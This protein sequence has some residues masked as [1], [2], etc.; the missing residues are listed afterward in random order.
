MH[1]IICGTGQVGVS[2]AG[3][4]ALENDV[5]IVDSNAERVQRTTETHDV[6]GMIGVP[7]HPDILKQAGAKDADMIIAVTE[8][9]E[10]NMIACQVAHSIFGTPL[11]I[12][13]IR[14]RSYL[15]PLVG[16]LYSPENLPIDHIISPESEVSEA[17]G[18]RLLVPGAFDVASM[19]EKKVRIV[20]VRCEHNCPILDSSLRQLTKLFE[21]LQITV[22][23]ILRGNELIVPRDG[24]VKMEEGDRVYFVCDEEQMARAMASFGHEEPASSNVLIAGAGTVGKMVAEEVLSL[25]ED[26]R[27]T[28]IEYNAETANEAA[29]TLSNAITVINGNAL[30]AEILQESEVADADTFIALTDDD[31]V[32]VLSSLL[33][34]RY[35]ATHTVAL[36]NMVS[37]VPLISNLGVDSVINPPA[38]TVSSI[39]KHVRRGKVGDIHTIAED[40]GEFMEVE[41][42]PSSPLVGVPLRSAKLPKSI[43]VGAVVHDGVVTAPRGDTVIEPGDRVVLFAAREAIAE[44]E[45]LLSVSPDFF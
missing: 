13:R 7:S 10:I 17:V 37:F 29:Q 16:D 15:D 14:A 21:G 35:G 28:M 26:S 2:I 39:L 45:K 19:V 34:K 30:E 32:N 38:M 8:S 23:A 33:A 31:E 24:S 1:I 11:K 44:L 18:S 42:M 22:V 40:R 25:I 9:D 12:G 3:H 4:L 6:R 27:C 36:V 5:T 41:A 20:G 43:A